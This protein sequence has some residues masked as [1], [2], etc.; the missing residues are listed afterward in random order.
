MV[1]NIHLKIWAQFN[2]H[3]ADD[4]AKWSEVMKQDDAV[5]ESYISPENHTKYLQS[6]LAGQPDY[7]MELN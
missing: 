2:F 4:Q 5:K 3:I 7:E 6:H 1:N